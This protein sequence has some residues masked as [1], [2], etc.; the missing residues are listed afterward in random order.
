MVG[1]RVIS[2]QSTGRGFKSW[3]LHCTALSATLDK[4]RASITTKQYNWH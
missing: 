3:L 2:M 4:T 1:D